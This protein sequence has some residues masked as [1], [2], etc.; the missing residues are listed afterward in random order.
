LNN[1]GACGG[2]YEPQAYWNTWLGQ[3]THR[4][5]WYYSAEQ[6]LGFCGAVRSAATVLADDPIFGRFCF[7]GTVQTN[8]S[9][10]EIVPLDGIRRRFHALLAGGTLHIMLD[11]DRFA[12]GQP[13]VLNSD[14]SGITVQIESDNPNAHVVP[15]HLS[16]PVSAPY[17]IMAGAAV[18]A[19]GTL[20]AGQDTLIQLP[21]L[22]GANTAPETFS[23]SY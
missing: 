13:L 3:N 8:G 12:A 22:A 6:N 10:M 21:L 20:T 7:G 11:A 9:G 2:G 1:D 4:G 14:L 5:P 19:S 23:I 15:L 18:A 16:A 17:T